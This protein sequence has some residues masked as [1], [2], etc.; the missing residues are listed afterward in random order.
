MVSAL[1]GDSKRKIDNEALLTPEGLK[2]FMQ[3]RLLSSTSSA[4]YIMSLRR[5]KW[6]WHLDD[7]N[8]VSTNLTHAQYLESLPPLKHPATSLAVPWSKGKPDNNNIE[9]YTDGSKIDDNGSEP[10]QSKVGYAIVVKQNGLTIDLISNRL[11][12]EASIY[13]AELEAI[14]QAVI[15]IKN[16]N[17][18]DAKIYTDS[19]S[20][21]QSLNDPRNRNKIIE[22]IKVNI[23]PS[24]KLYW[25][26][27]H[28]GI[29]G[30]EEADQQAK[31]ATS[32]SRV[33]TMLPVER[34]FIIRYIKQATMNKWKIDWSESTKGRQTY[35]FFKDPTLT[36]L[37]SNF[38]LN[39]F[40]TGHGVFGIYQQ[41]FF[42]K[43]ANCKFCGKVQDID[44]L[45]KFCP[46]FQRIRGRK[47]DQ[48]TQHQ[49]YADIDC[50]EKIIEILEYTLDDLLAPASTPD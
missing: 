38:Y 18:K 6:G 35:N 3:S 26:K 48:Y 50:R 30:N 7:L 13:L 31:K 1:N 8:L 23:T 45:I 27:A 37:Q 40:L 34:T 29:E 49:L 20:S 36:R 43:R 41:K 33:G 15:Y 25:V 11:N 2:L 39:Q 24:I 5:L 16:K 9:I 42:N 28:I 14:K 47:L 44:H 17:Y 32:F 22:E 46:K 19:L 4:D 21:L 10:M 12:D